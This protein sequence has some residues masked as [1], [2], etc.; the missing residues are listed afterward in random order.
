MKLT[1]QKQTNQLQNLAANLQVSN[2]QTISN[3]Q[4]L[5]HHKVRQTRVKIS[6]LSKKRRTTTRVFEYVQQYRV[7]CKQNKNFVQNLK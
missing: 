2:L 4:A 1:L 5:N 6:I 3:L 7:A